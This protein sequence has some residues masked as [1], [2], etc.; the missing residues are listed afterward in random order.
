MPGPAPWR[1][2]CLDAPKLA[3]GQ[4]GRHG[5]A[6]PA[7]A[8]RRGDRRRG[9]GR[10]ASLIFDQAENRL[11]AQKALLASCSAQSDC[12]AGPDEHEP[13]D[14]GSAGT[15]SIASILSHK[16]V[17]VRSQEELA[18]LLGQRGVR[19]TQA[20]LSRD[21]EELGAVRLRGRRRRAGLR[22][23]RGAGTRRPW[24]DSRRP[25]VGRPVRAVGGRPRGAA[26]PGG[27]RAS[28]QCR[29]QRQ[30][31]GAAHAGRG[32]AAARLGHRP[33]RLAGRPWH[34]GRRRHRARHRP[35]PRRGS[36]PRAGAPAAG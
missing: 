13:A 14:Q 11:H 17:P 35:R 5:A 21:L 15:R 34:R 1:C 9:H 3:L 10:P 24:R 6:L 26:D 27:C 32:R 22:P 36:G 18:E 12:P 25:V 8:S 30:P 4:P 31:R 7:R 20:T 19:V 23:A 33:R 28:G 29:G 2:Y 16:S